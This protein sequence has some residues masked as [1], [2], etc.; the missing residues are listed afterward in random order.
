MA[1]GPASTSTSPSAT[2]RKPAGPA[3]PRD[4]FVA[5][6]RVLGA[7]GARG[8]VRLES[9]TDFPERFALGTQLWL[10]GERRAVEHSH[11]RRDAVV[12]QFGGIDSREAASALRGAL[13][14]LPDAE[15]HPLADGQ[16]YQHDLIGLMVQGLAGDELGRVT[17]LLA[18]GANDVL[19]ADGPAGE[20]LIP[21]IED[22]VV[23]V[24]L[25]AGAIVVDLPGG[26]EPRPAPAGRRSARRIS[27][28]RRNRTEA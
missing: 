6:A 23:R 14:E 26:L 16:F 4:G 10:D 13:I 19:V 28:P 2:G 20:Y 15:L 3:E 24:D 7:W 25:S 11:W 27:R 12:V 5:V 22:V 1:R 21:M 9:L 18:T 17:Q 8:A